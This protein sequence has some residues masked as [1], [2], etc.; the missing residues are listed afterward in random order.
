MLVREDCVR[1][2]IVFCLVLLSTGACLGQVDSAPDTNQPRVG[3]ALSGGGALGLAHVG[4]LKYFEEHRIPV[5]AIAGTSM[6][7]MVGALYATGNDAA[8]LER[9]ARTVD[10]DEIFETAPVYPERAVVEKQAWHRSNSGVTLRLQH[11]LSLPAGINTGQPLALLLSRY[12]AAYSELK[13]FDDLP[14]PF[15]CVATDLTRAEAFTLDHGSL[16]L[17]LRATMALPGIYT[18]VS[19]ED[20]I[21]VDGGAVDN[22]PVDV[23]RTMNTDVVIAVSLNVAPPSPKSLNS[24]T[25]VLRQVVNV[26]V[27]E[28]ER[29]SLR[30]ADLVI[31]VQLQDYNSLDYDKVEQIM[32]S[33][34]QAA[35]LMADKLKPYEL[36]PAEWQEYVESRKHRMRTIPEKG[37]VVSVQSPV[38]TVQHDATHEL[39]RKL[40]GEV[41]RHQLEDTL[42]GITAATSLPS[43]YYGWHFGEDSGY[44]VSLEPRPEGGE[45]LIRPS[46]L[47][48]VSGGEPTR[49]SLRTSWVRSAQDS[50]KSRLLGQVT[51]G[52]DPGIRFEF[53]RPSDGNAYFFAPGAMYQRWHD[54]SYAGSTITQYYRDRVAGTLYGGLGTWR[55]VQWRVG[56]TAGYDSYNREVVTDGV[57]SSSTGFADLETRLLVDT[58]NSGLLPSSG[59]RMNIAAGYSVRNYSFPYFDGGFSHFI[60]LND[61]KTRPIS[62][63][64][65]G[66]GATSFGRKLPYFNQFTAG[67]FA[68]LS[69]Y[70]YQ[71]F[72]ANTLFTGGG[73]AYFT[74][75]KWKDFKPVLTFWDEVAR[76][77]LGS[78]G[79]QT[80]NSANSGVFLPTPLGS[81]GVV[82]SFTEDGRARFRFVFGKF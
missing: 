14:I 57:T 70:R 11:N 71:E 23:A 68:D 5:Y 33:G 58:Q 12:T 8:G 43:A 55:F 67:G 37:R 28:N 59:T 77:D 30:E 16:P 49:T 1:K 75:P 6:G 17:A 7:G 20:R 34:Y 19:W 74:L 72:H 27:L 31:P 4:V 79:W 41:D 51:I 61:S 15:R 25:S 69:A 56:T 47:L 29:R 81:A 13:S 22:I 32:A 54:D 39:R 38:P 80:H 66:R 44:K 26:V 40:P 63:F 52:F 82:L 36:S 9:I 73:G 48:Q 42:T 24:I 46:L 2:S 53:F 76:L 18:P 78:Q 65:L 10:F 21:L 62:T 60:P 35:K 3:L 45:V 50:Y 64:V